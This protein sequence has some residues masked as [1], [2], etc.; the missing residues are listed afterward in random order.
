ML[1]RSRANDVTVDS[2]A[3]ILL[4]D[5]HPA[6]RHG[7]RAIIEEQGNF[8]VVAEATCGYEAI[9]A[10]D[11]YHPDL[12]VLDYQLPGVTGLVIAPILAR[13]SP[14]SRI[15][16]LSAFGDD[17]TMRDAMEAGAVAYVTKHHD[18]SVLLDILSSVVAGDTPRSS[19]GV[20][21]HIPALP[22]ERHGRVSL[23]TDDGVELEPLT[24]REITILDCVVQGHRYRTCA[25]NLFLSEATIKNNVANILSKWGLSNRVHLFLIAISIGWV[26][27]TATRTERPHID[28][29]RSVS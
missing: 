4:V 2:R 27:I 25:E 19:F 12:I 14:K 16:F 1:R 5:D 22:G 11:Q 17:Q 20:G 26:Q 29:V 28:R 6:F 23:V 10:A 18:P 15:V 8:R 21:D 3:S 9:Y 13:R 24:A 7:L